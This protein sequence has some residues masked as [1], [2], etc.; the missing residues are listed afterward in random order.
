MPN[1]ALNIVE[2]YKSVEVKDFEG[3]AEMDSSCDQEG[4]SVVNEEPL[5]KIKKNKTGGKRRHFSSLEELDDYSIQDSDKDLILSTTSEEDFHPK[6]EDNLFPNE[7]S[8]NNF[9][10]VKILEKQTNHL[11]FLL[12]KCNT[13]IQMMMNTLEYSKKECLG[14]L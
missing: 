12:P 8:P 13:Q 14:I 11:D 1:P 10:M 3:P 4:P 6:Y 2:I 7:F 5:Y 9:V